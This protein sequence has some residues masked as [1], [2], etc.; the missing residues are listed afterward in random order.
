MVT[1]PVEPSASPAHLSVRF[2]RETLPLQGRLFVGALHLTGKRHDAED[3]LQETMLRAFAGF[4]SFREGTN[5]MSWLYRIMHNVWV[6][7]YRIRSRRPPEL[8][9]ADFHQD[10]LADCRIHPWRTPEVAALESIPD[11]TLTAAIGALPEQYQVTLYY[12]D[13]AGLSYKEVAAA[14][15]VSVGTVMSRLH[16]GRR[17]LRASLAAKSSDWQSADRRCPASSRRR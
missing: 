2:E 8:L 5:L 7:G 15:G 1:S 12:A 11:Q 9:V 17:R 13:V 16:R 4:E 3:L 10:G 14:T 6:D